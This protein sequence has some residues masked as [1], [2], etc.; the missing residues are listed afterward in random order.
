MKPLGKCSVQLLTALSPMLQSVKSGYYSL[1]PYSSTSYFIQLGVQVESVQN[2]FIYYP[3]RLL[4]HK[5]KESFKSVLYSFQ[6]GLCCIKK[7]FLYIFKMSMPFFSLSGIEASF[8]QQ[9][10]IHSFIQNIYNECLLSVEYY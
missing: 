1:P 7:K 2:S 4:P 5:R 10:F 3:V 9:P 6:F 8:T